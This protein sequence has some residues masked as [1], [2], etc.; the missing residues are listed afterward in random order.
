VGEERKWKHAQAP[1]NAVFC[2]LGRDMPWTTCIGGGNVAHLGACRESVN[3]TNK[4]IEIVFILSDIPTTV[5][6]SIGRLEALQ[7]G[8]DGSKLLS[9]GRVPSVVV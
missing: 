7:L 5:Q 4:W 1:H 6:V 2:V 9:E 8:V 3:S